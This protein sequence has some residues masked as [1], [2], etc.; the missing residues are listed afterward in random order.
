MSCY[1][2]KAALIN[3]LTLAKHQITVSNVKGSDVS[4]KPA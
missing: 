2:F 3:I 4:D 1:C